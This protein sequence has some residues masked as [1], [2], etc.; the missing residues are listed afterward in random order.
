MMGVGVGVVVQVHDAVVSRFLCMR[1]GMSCCW[2]AEWE[3]RLRDSDWSATTWPGCRSYSVDH[4]RR[5]C[6]ADL[7]LATDQLVAVGSSSPAV[8]QYA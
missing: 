5:C 4:R 2:T 7:L 3:V 6:S 1:E 8:V